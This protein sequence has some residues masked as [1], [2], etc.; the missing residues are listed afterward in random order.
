MRISLTVNGVENEREIEDRQLLSD[1]LRDDLGLTGTNVGCAHGVC[2]SCTVHVDGRAVR[3]CTT[4]AAQADGCTVRTVEDLCPPGGDLHPLQ[5]AFSERHALQCGFC[6]PG[7]LM[8]ALPAVERG[9]A[10]DDVEARELISGNL[11][12]C[13]GYDGIVEAVVDASRHFATG[14]ST[15]AV[16]SNGDAA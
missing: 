5:A 10:I 1:F 8:T 2:G 15:A 7:F 11:C 3:S 16:E 4:L 9:I 14:V 6:T 12:R 13:T